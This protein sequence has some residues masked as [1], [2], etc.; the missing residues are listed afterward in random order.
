VPDA[1]AAAPCFLLAV[2]AGAGATVILAT[3]LGL[4]VS[5]THA[6]TGALVGAGFAA[7]GPQLNLAHLGTGF[8]VPLLLSPLLAVLLTLPLYRALRALAAR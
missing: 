4:P 6:L 7:V 3:L 2:A 1:V 5:S 8:F